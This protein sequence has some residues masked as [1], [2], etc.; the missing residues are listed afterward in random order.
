MMLTINFYLINQPHVLINTMFIVMVIN[1]GV[2]RG[3]I[4]PWPPFGKKKFLT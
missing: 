3:D 1:R 4:G 2:F